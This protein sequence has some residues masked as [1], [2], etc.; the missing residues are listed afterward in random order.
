MQQDLQQL[1]KSYLKETKQEIIQLRRVIHQKPEPS[2][3]EYET[4]DL[5]YSK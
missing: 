3:E 5:I 1:L 4:A 2:F